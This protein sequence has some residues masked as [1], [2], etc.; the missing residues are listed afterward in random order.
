MAERGRTMGGY[1][2]QK[3]R[4]GPG[5]QTFISHPPQICEVWQTS[6]LHPK[7]GAPSARM[8]TSPSHV[9]SASSLP[10]KHTHT[11]THTHTPCREAGEP[12]QGLKG[13]DLAGMRDW[14]LESVCMC[15]CV[16]G[17]G[18]SVTA[19]EG[20]RAKESPTRPSPSPVTSDF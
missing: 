9:T 14:G 16:L 5:D 11:H 7:H 10:P 12:S 17:G 13:L 18:V 2:D 3:A 4:M 20:Q 15:V 6:S 1:P 8:T 19:L